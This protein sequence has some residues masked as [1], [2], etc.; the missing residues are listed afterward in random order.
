MKLREIKKHLFFDRKSATSLP[1]GVPIG[2]FVVDLVRAIKVN[3][4]S[5][6]AGWYCVRRGW[7][8]P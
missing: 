6:W 7:Q 3:Q 5:A 1:F 2:Y 4:V 8:M